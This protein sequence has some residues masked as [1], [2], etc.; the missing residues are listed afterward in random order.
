[1]TWQIILDWWCFTIN[2]QAMFR[3][4]EVGPKWL[5]FIHSILG[6]WKNNCTSFSIKYPERL[7][8]IILTFLLS[9]TSSKNKVIFLTMCK[10]DILLLFIYS[11]QRFHPSFRLILAASLPIQRHSVWIYTSVTLF[12]F[13]LTPSQLSPPSHTLHQQLPRFVTKL[14]VI[15]KGP[16]PHNTAGEHGCYMCLTPLLPATSS[17]P[18]HRKYLIPLSQLPAGGWLPAIPRAGPLLFRWA[19]PPPVADTAGVGGGTQWDFSRVCGY[20]AVC[21][22]QGEGQ[23][24]SLGE[25]WRP[26]HV[27]ANLALAAEQWLAMFLGMHSPLFRDGRSKRCSPASAKEKERTTAEQLDL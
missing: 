23:T 5:E 27:P 1:M 21:R 22:N 19:T 18:S 9:K 26:G 11:E 6:Q 20:H 15:Q 7:L 4:A 24:K 3:K 12:S 10:K 16:E 2:F 14:T 17:P 25:P 8:L 13:C